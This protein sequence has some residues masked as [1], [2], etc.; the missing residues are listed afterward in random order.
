MSEG[1]EVTDQKQ[2]EEEATAESPGRGAEGVGDD[3]EEGDAGDGMTRWR[4]A[5]RDRVGALIRRSHDAYMT[6]AFPAAELKPRS[7]TGGEFVLVNISLV[8][9][10]DSLDTLAIVGNASEFDRCVDIVTD[11]FLPAPVSS[12][13][14]LLR[15][16]HRASRRGGRSLTST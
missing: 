12:D 16:S 11:F 7:C 6:H 2:G 15:G 13:E 5:M 4:L 8:T 3:D 14:E 10:V 9:L 1:L